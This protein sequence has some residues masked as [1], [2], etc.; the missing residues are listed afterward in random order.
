MKIT[1]RN[2]KKYPIEITLTDGTKMII[3]RQSQFSNEWLK[4]H[5]CSIMAEY[6][7]LQ[8]LG[9]KTVKVNGKNKGLYPINLLRWHKKN[10]PDDI[11]AKVMLTGVEKGIDDLSKGD[12]KYYKHTTRD[13][14]R[15]ALDK[16]NLV[17]YEQKDPI[18]TVILI[19]DEGKIWIA[20]HGTV[21]ETT[22]AQE[23]KKAL[24]KTK[25]KGM[26]VVAR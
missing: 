23:A 13:R 14:M 7:A 4:K 6:I 12:G 11:A 1:K 25:Y 22:T 16:G 3:P 18:H 10:T 26:V 9:V 2:S 24:L 8:W 5:G 20:N 15:D 17:I 19:P 21:K